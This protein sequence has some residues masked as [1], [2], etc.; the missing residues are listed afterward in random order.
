MVKT[1]I[2]P[3]SDNPLPKNALSDTNQPYDQTVWK[4]DWKQGYES[5]WQES[6][7]WIE[8]VEGQIPLDLQG[9]LFRNGPGSLDVNGQPLL[10]PIDGDGMICAIAF[11]QGRAYFRNR[12]VRTEGFLAEQMA[13]R[14]LYRG[15]FG[16]QK[17]GGWLA[18]AFDLR[19][20][21][22]ANTSVIYWGDRLLALWEAAEPYRLSPDNLE[23]LGLDRL[24]GLL[25]PGEAFSAHPRIDPGSER[26][27]NQ[28]RLINFG[29]KQGLSSKIA[30]YEIDPSWTVVQRQT[31]F[32]PGFALLHDFAI[33]PNYYLFFQNPLSFNPLPYLLGWSSAFQSLKFQPDRPSNIILIPRHD[34]TKPI[35]ILPTKNC[36]I[37]HHANA[38][39]QDNRIYLDSSTYSTFATL[40]PNLPYHQIDFDT[41]PAAELW[42]F[43]I[44]LSSNTV[45]PHPIESRHCEFPSLRPDRMGRPY[46]Y[47]YL[48]AAEALRGNAPGQ[49]ILKHDLKTGEQQAWSVAPRGFVGEPAFVP[50]PNGTAEDD[51]W[52]LTLIYNAE[53]HR[54]ELAILDA[55]NVSCGTVARLFLKYHIPHGL[56]GYFTQQ[57][58]GP[59]F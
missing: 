48:S 25:K 10:H 5:Q 11:S 29:V 18:N 53:T 4:A 40:E 50:R 16:T 57:Y 30:L 38:F 32:I 49:V 31:R 37:F 54:S 28:P 27:H 1:S 39:E 22:T 58:F 9:T 55:R 47:L 20:K 46:Q 45:Q 26:T 34:T 33:T 35:R 42:R 56:H 15:P 52:L 43:E 21:N 36:F 19:L 7:Y 24:D 14:I 3:L 51:G 13:G 59:D 12:F 2:N 23:T 8:Q 44:D 17:P 41:Y 6:E